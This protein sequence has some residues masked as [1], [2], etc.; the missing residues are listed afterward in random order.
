[1]FEGA[2][3]GELRK[4]L[5]DLTLAR[6]A[7]YKI[8]ELLVTELESEIMEREGIREVWECARC[9]R[10]QTMFVRASAVYCCGREA[11]KVWASKTAL[12]P[13]S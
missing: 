12:S 7:G 1:M 6:D 10:A 8:P 2:K 9:H 5:R 4:K 3:L 13:P 11:K